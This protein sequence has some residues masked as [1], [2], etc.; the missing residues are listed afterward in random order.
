LSC[1]AV[2]NARRRSTDCDCAALYGGF[3]VFAGGCEP[4][5]ARTA[6]G[7]DFDAGR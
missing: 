2:L 4:E 5:R 1:G 6:L 3:D 7:D